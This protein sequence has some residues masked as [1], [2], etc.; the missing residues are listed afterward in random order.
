MGAGAAWIALTNVPGCKLA[1]RAT[2]TTPST[3]T[4][5]S[6]PPQ[7]A[8][9]F[10]SRPDL[11]PPA[12]DVTQQAHY[13]TPGYIFAAPKKAGAGQRGTLIVDDR[14]QVVWFRHPK[15]KHAFAMDFKVQHY[16]GE[17]VLT[18]W[19]GTY[20]SRVLD[21]YVILDSFYSEIT[22]IHPGNGYHE[23]DH[24]EFLISPQDT[25]L[26]T[27]YNPVRWDLSPVGGPKDGVAWQGIVQELDIETGRVLFEWHS[28]DHVSLDEAYAKP[29]E[30]PLP[31]IDYFHINSIDVDHDDNLLVSARRTS[32]VYKIDRESGEIIWRLGGKKSSFEMGPGTQFAYQHDARRQPDGTITIF[33]N[34]TTIFNNRHA[35]AIVES[36][37]I[38]LGLDEEKMTAS[39][40]REYTHPHKLFADTGGSVQV[41]PNG[42][43]F[44]GWGSEPVFSEF[45]SDGELLFDASLPPR[46]ASYRTFRFPWSGHPSDR[47]VAVAERASDEEVRV[48]ASWNGAT[49]V[50]TWEVLAG[51]SPNQ[52]EP[53]RSV[54]WAG[55]ET[56]ML[57]R[58]KKPYIAVQAK[59]RSGKVLGTTECVEQ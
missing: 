21:E 52:L 19:E 31:G 59:D 33:D 45:S 12:V 36:R 5:S 10:R 3:A 25:A 9:T 35:K 58:T 55:F 15:R 47:P 29:S 38:V 54:R 28:L 40:V 1:E 56:A 6:A 18:W 48:Y 34:G 51:L 42:N 22:R 53:V 16:R 14:G 43:V 4:S 7:A 26:T 39:L 27:I 23:G 24:H 49:Q 13:T 32:T 2:K 17:L 8:W 57:V 11:N 50:T 20:G 41:L 46:D 37:A 30:G 44:V